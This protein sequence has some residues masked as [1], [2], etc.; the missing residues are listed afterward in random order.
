MRSPRL[1]GRVLPAVA[2]AVLVAGCGGGFNQQSGGAPGS[3]P[4]T[5]TS[6]AGG[7]PGATS[8]SSLPHDGDDHSEP[9]FPADTRPDTGQASAGARGTITDVRVGHHDGF[10]R[11]VFE[12]HGTGTPGWTVTYVPAATAQGSGRPI[13]VAG[14]AVLSV[15][16][17]GVGY[18]TD[19]GIQEFRRGTVS[20]ADTDVVTEAFFNGTFE[21]ISQAFVGTTAQRPFRVYLLTD[22]VRVVLDVREH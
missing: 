9:P 6:S 2:L 16:L 15:A 19:T 21:G 1:P 5:A 20:G 7:T 18:P 13:D 4:S 10:D 17:T 14:N 22:P 8:S 3:S 11:V 12:F